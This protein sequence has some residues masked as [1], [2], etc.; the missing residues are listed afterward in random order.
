MKKFEEKLVTCLQTWMRRQIEAYQ[1]F[2]GQRSVSTQTTEETEA[3]RELARR[4]T[5]RRLLQVLGRTMQAVGQGLEF[6]GG[7]A[8]WPGQLDQIESWMNSQIEALQQ[9]QQ[10]FAD[11]GSVSTQTTNAPSRPVPKQSKPSTV[12]PRYQLST[13][14]ESSYECP[15]YEPLAGQDC[16]IHL[17]WT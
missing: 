14:E 9:L 2:A 1:K 5:Q 17:T 12:D 11:Q 8:P 7:A 6:P 4:Q 13:D 3:A 16:E 10:I 15:C